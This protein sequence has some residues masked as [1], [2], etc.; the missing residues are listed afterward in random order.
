MFW[1]RFISLFDR[2]TQMR[3]TVGRVAAAQQ[4]FGARYGF[5]R[6]ENDLV[7]HNFELCHLLQCSFKAALMVPCAVNERQRVPE[8]LI[9]IGCPKDMRSATSRPAAACRLNPA[10]LFS[11]SP[12]KSA[13]YH[14]AGSRSILSKSAYEVPISCFAPAISRLVSL[15]DSLIRASD[16]TSKSRSRRLRLLGTY[17][18]SC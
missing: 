14:L 8:R 10:A 2:L 7:R 18:L 13:A 9:K 5:T 16:E 3:T 15:A 17:R 6:L 11:R 1:G 4:L 12:V